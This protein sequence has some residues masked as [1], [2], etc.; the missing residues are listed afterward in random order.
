MGVALRSQG[1]LDESLSTLTEAKRGMN[2][3]LGETHIE[4]LG[5]GNSLALAYT[6]AGNLQ[7]A[8]LLTDVIR[9]FSQILGPSHPASLQCMLNLVSLQRQMGDLALA[10]TGSMQVLESLRSTL[11]GDHRSTLAASVIQGSVLFDLGKWQEAL[12]VDQESLTRLRTTRGHR[13]VHTLI[14]LSNYAGDLISTGQES[15]GGATRNEALSEMMILLGDGHPLTQ[16][17]RAGKRLD[18][19]IEIPSF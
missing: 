5:C 13:H 15:A 4:T 10:Q 14:T 8:A 11:G 1:Q 18:P 12:R 19:D 16:T 3:L 7:A 6:S 9:G 17:A 2:D